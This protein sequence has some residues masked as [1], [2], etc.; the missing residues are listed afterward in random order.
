MDPAARAGT[1]GA[2]WIAR[3]PHEKLRRKERPPLPS[4]DPF[5]QPPPGFQHA[6]PGTVLRSR[7][8]ELAFLGLIPQRPPPPS[9]CT[10]PPT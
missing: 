6:L 8:V 10:G 9:C 1:S 4:D 2:E 5:Y 3:P 7:D